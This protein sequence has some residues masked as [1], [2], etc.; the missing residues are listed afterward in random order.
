[1]S[2]PAKAGPILNEDHP[3]RHLTL[4]ALTA[5]VLA[6][7]VRADDGEEK[8]PLD[9][10][11]KAVLAAAKK[12]F[13]KA[14]AKE[15][16]KEVADGKTVYE[17]TFKENGKNIDVSL[18]PEGTITMIE[19][20]VAFKDLPKAVAATFDKKYPKATYGIIEEVT[21]VAGGKETVEYFEAHLTTADKK[22]LEAE[23]LADGK[24]KSEAE[25]KDEPKEKKNN[26]E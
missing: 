19:K 21:T 9:K 20:E 16:S 13:P 17:V 2:A 23:V 11:P 10:L 24:F 15:A 22:K 12:R 6:A 26:R 5:L 25:V 8:V 7:P 1:M 14:E 4:A 3:M 18:T